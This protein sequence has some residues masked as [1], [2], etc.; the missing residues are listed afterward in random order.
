M[1]GERGEQQEEHR[2]RQADQR[3]LHRMDREAAQELE[4]H[5]R[6]GGEADEEEAV[7]RGALEHLVEADGLDEGNS[8]L[9]VLRAL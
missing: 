1:L 6:R 5:E 9:L 3:V 2:Q 7:L 8:D 4:Q